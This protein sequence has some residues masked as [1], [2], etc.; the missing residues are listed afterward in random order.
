MELQNTSSDADYKLQ[1][2]SNTV[3]NW[4]RRANESDYD[5]SLVQVDVFADWATVVWGESHDVSHVQDWLRRFST[6]HPE[7]FMD[8]ENFRAY[9]RVLI[10]GRHMDDWQQQVIKEEV[11]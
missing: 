11:E 1:N 6:G 2:R 9:V 8:E 4:R 10:S 7:Q 3:R 5:L